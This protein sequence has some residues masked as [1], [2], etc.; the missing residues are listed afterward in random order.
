[1]KLPGLLFRNYTEQPGYI[2]S[3]G[4]VFEIKSQRAGQFTLFIAGAREAFN[5]SM[6]MQ[7]RGHQDVIVRDL[8]GKII[9]PINLRMLCNRKT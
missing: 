7:A 5:E 2:G 4:M 6:D 9:K 1:L 3:V 8:Q